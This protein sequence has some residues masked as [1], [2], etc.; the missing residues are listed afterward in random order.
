MD[1]EVQKKH[2]ISERPDFERIYRELAEKKNISKP[3]G[4]LFS[5]QKIWD[6][7]D[8]IDT[9]QYLFENSLKD[10]QKFNQRL[11]SYDESSIK[12]ILKYQQKHKL[13]N[14]QVMLKFKISRNT[15]S[16][17]KKLFSEDTTD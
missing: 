14:S 1:S 8:V 7:L 15:I 6:S 12:K 16:K 17:W 11:R 5:E 9:N 10:V 13:N 3:L 4:H 2:N